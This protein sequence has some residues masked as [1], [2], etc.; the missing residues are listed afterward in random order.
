MRFERWLAVRGRPFREIRDALR[1]N[2][3]HQFASMKEFAES[4]YDSKRNAAGAVVDGRVFGYPSG[5]WY[6]LLLG[7]NNWHS[8]AN[9]D[10][11][12]LRLSEEGGEVVN[13]GFGFDHERSEVR[14][15][16]NDLRQWSIIHNNEKGPYHLQ[17]TGTVPECYERIKSI[18]ID[19]RLP[20][21]P[22]DDFSPRSLRDRHKKYRNSAFEV[23][24]RV[25]RAVTDYDYDL[26]APTAKDIIHCFELA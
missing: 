2:S 15:Y 8:V 13:T 23:P 9:G 1:A 11:V 18:I 12:A 21:P 20:E 7:Q 26:C 25:S 17:T 14:A 22:K 24:L 3:V 6:I 16:H 19:T 10:A 5:E 4:R